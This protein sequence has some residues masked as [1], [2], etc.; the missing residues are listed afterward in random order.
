MLFYWFSFISLLILARKNKDKNANTEKKSEQNPIIENNNNNTNKQ[1]ETNTTNDKTTEKIEI[2]GLKICEAF[3]ASGLRSIRYIKELSGISKIIAND[4]DGK[5]LKT[6]TKRNE[7][8]VMFFFFKILAVE[9]I[10]KNLEFNKVDQKVVIPNL[11][12]AR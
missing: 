9:M 7:C 8:F 6:G 4:I 1:E 5:G 11:G 2:P 12:D 10:K 3:S